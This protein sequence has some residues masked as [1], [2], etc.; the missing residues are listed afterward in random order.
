M[1]DAFGAMLPYA[2]GLLVSPL[3]VAAVIM[4]LVSAGGRRKAAVFEVTWLVVSLA[5]LLVTAVIV[6][7]APARQRGATPTWESVVAIV[8]GVIMLVMA[9]IIAVTW[10]RRSGPTTP[11]RWMHVLDVLSPRKTVGLAAVLIIAN[12]VNLGMLLA[13]GIELGQFRLRAGAELAAAALFVLT[14]SLTMLAPWLITLASGRDAGFL[15][16]ARRWLL[17]HNDA[18]SFWMTF[19]FGILFL[20]KGLRAQL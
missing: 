14:G 12:P 20:T 9:L 4:L 17:R 5:L 3:P 19:G 6:G 8:L 11:P 16:K 10:R 18:L 2:T 7:N 15:P 13:A 1:W